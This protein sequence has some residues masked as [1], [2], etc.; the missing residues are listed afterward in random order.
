MRKLINTETEPRKSVAYKTNC[1][2]DNIS[3]D[4]YNVNSF[5]AHLFIKELGKMF[6]KDLILQ[7]LQKT[8]RI[9]LSL[10]SRPTSTWLFN[11]DDKKVR[12][13]FFLYF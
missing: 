1:V 7:S 10:M 9:T 11:K 13:I 12:K 2:P 8:R 4:L 3:I 6:V 5:D